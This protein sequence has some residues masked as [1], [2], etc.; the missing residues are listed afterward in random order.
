[1][2]GK[3]GKQVLLFEGYLEELERLEE[4]GT[5]TDFP[6]YMEDKMRRRFL[7]AFREIDPVWE[8]YSYI[9][10]LVDFREMTSVGLGELPD[11]LPI[12]EDGEYTDAPLP[13]YTGPVIQLGTFGRSFTIG[14]RV[15]IN[16]M[17]NRINDIPARFG[18]A[19]R[20]SLAKRVVAILANNATAYDGTA[21]FHADHDNLLSVA[22]SEATLPT[23]INALRLQTD[24]NGLRIDLPARYLLHPI[25]LN[26]TAQRI[27]NG[28]M[29][30]NAGSGTTPAYGQT[31]F[32]AMKAALIPIE[33]PY[34]TDANDWYVLTEPTQETALV[35]VGF[36]NGNREPD[37][38]LK[39]PGMRNVLGGN[40]PYSFH[41]D[42]IEYKIRHDWAT[43]PG[44]FRGG[45]KSVV[46]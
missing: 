30:P 41:F 46:A 25:E 3:V 28:T 14:R 15:I 40:D 20:R 4:A 18:R 45:V 17:L 34:L 9:Q 19:A 29:I 21:L 11:L 13:E 1:M 42:R 16:D 31:E 2:Y 7:K 26:Y 39:D 8:R 32:H 24:Q 22:L 6:T 10:N 37:I 12:A 38:M 36:L 27:L 23:A 5:T 43:A 44:E 33:D 35:T